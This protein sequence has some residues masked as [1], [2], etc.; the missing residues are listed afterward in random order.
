RRPLN[1]VEMPIGQR[2]EAPRIDRRA[3]GATISNPESLPTEKECRR[4]KTR[5][6]ERGQ[7]VQLDVKL[8]G[9]RASRPL[10]IFSG[11]RSLKGRKDWPKQEATAG[12]TPALPGFSRRNLLHP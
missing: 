4:I 7:L 8:L 12:G 6:K 11:D 1:Q 3:H 5:K 2:I 10:E 9:E